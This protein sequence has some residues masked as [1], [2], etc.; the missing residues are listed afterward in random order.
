MLGGV[1]WWEGLWTDVR[2]A[3]VYYGEDVKRK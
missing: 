3:G 1:K 2:G